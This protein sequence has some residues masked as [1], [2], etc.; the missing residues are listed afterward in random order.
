MTDP[1]LPPRDRPE[2]VHHSTI[3]NPAPA[4]SGG[5]GWIAF[6]V[7]GLVVV[8]IIIAVVMYSNRGGVV[9]TP[10]AGDVNVDVSLPRPDLPDPPKMPDLPNVEPPTVSQPAPAPAN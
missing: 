9:P 3:N 2:V 10:D 6:L 8:A 7:G 1:S 5:N 4:R